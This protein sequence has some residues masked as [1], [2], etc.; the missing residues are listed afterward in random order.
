MSD[1]GGGRPPPVAAEETYFPGLE[2]WNGKDLT[3]EIAATMSAKAKV[4]LACRL[5]L[6]HCPQSGDEVCIVELVLKS[7]Y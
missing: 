5:A 3:T 6:F 2:P 7:V 4:P 1:T